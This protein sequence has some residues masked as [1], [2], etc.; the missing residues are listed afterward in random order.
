MR[1]RVNIEAA[2]LS[3]GCRSA[4]DRRVRLVKVFSKAFRIHLTSVMRAI[5]Y[6]SRRNLQVNDY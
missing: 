4:L 1:C 5:E 3:M 2:L 6:L